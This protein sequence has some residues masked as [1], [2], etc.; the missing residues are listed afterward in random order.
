MIAFNE[1]SLLAGFVIFCRVGLCLAFAPGFSSPRITFR[2][3]LF[4]AI[5]LTIA[6]CPAFIQPALEK[7]RD[8]DV[9]R[10][11]QVIATECLIGA[12][13]G[14]LARF[15]VASLETMA[16]AIAMA[17]S[18]GSVLGGRIDEN[19]TM[20]EFASLIVLTVTTLMF[21]TD[22]HWEIIRAVADSYRAFPLG[23]GL[24]A[25]YALR[26]LGETLSFAFQIS[27]RIASPFLVFGLVANFAFGLVNKVAPQIS[28]YFVSVPFL[29][30]CGMALAYITSGNLLTLFMAAF[31]DWLKRG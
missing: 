9:V 20:P 23:D 1:E 7:M 6:L 26:R 15:M 27:L 10:L 16:V 8:A 5:G 11:A 14:L 17:T 4:I 12:A 21:V 13:I 25:A 3:R 22:L 28:V 18:M 30:C 19:E 2:V 31:A 29:I 24:P